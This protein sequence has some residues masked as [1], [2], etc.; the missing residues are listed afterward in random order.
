MHPVL[1]RRSNLLLYLCAWIP[2]VA[3]LAFLLE[4]SGGY[5]WTEASVLAVPMGLILAFLSLSAWYLCRAL[6]LSRSS[7]LRLLAIFT[8]AALISSAAWI[9]IGR[10]IVLLLARIPLVSNID[11]RYYQQVPLF[12][13]AGVLLFL[14]SAAVHYLMSAFEDSRAAEERALKLQVLAREAELKALRAQVDPHFLFNSLNSISALTSIDAV[15]ARQMCQLLADFLRKSLELGSEDFITLE[16]EIAL[17]RDFL[18]IERV[19][20]GPRLTVVEEVAEAARDCLVPSLVIQPLVENAVTHGIARSVEG[21][22]VR[23]E[24]SLRGDRLSICIANPCGDASQSPRVKGF[25]L[26]NTRKRLMALYGREARVDVLNA[27]ESFRVVL[28][29]PAGRA[30]KR[31]VGGSEHGTAQ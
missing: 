29:F 9:A 3:L 21:G 20:F 2:V 7:Y 18:A 8:A 14:N 28:S 10:G 22:T 1:A 11:E 12:F 5:D 31:N 27:N 6:P 4:S 24:S 19:R 26:E 23:I 25:G 16:K 30:L 15:R 13:A 17:A